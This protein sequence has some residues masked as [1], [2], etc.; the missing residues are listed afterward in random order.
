MS[1]REGSRVSSFRHIDTHVGASVAD[2]VLASF[3][4]EKR[5]VAKQV[6]GELENV[7]AEMYPERPERTPDP[8]IEGVPNR[9]QR[10]KS[11]NTFGSVYGGKPGG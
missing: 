10:T 6:L 3:G 4:G 1:S 11:I 7:L 8:L 2:R 9:P 5:A